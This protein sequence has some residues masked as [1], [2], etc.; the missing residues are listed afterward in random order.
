[1]EIAVHAESEDEARA[2]ADVEGEG[3]AV[4]EGV[5]QSGDYEVHPIADNS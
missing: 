1:M 5:N 3:V 4:A 2:E